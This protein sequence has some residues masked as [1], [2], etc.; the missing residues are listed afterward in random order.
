MSTADVIGEE[1][2]WVAAMPEPLRAPALKLNDAV[3]EP[4]MKK[5]A[6]ALCRIVTFCQ[7][8]AQGSQG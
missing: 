4:I 1:Q 8:I 3:V 6:R 7:L 5:C 2:A